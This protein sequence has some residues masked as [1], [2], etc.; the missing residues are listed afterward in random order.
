MSLKW[1]KQVLLA[2]VCVALL[3]AC[4]APPPLDKLAS[5]L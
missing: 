5:M 3:A 1:L 2:T 4:S